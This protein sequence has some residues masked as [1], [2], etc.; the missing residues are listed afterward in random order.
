MYMHVL[1]IF[2]AGWF[3]IEACVNGHT[4]PPVRK[5]D[6]KKNNDSNGME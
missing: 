5:S 2:T 1:F 4:I 6:S 3:R